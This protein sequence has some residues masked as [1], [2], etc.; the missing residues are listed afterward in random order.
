MLVNIVM[1]KIRRVMSG[2]KVVLTHLLTKYNQ[3]K[4]VEDSDVNRRPTVFQSSADPPAVYTSGSI[5][6]LRRHDPLPASLEKDIFKVQGLL[7]NVSRLW[8]VGV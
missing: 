8:Y 7:G 3:Q 6:T 5:I 2:E 1:P 4:G